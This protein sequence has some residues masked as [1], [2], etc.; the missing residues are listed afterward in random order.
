[1]TNPVKGAPPRLIYCKPWQGGWSDGVKF[2]DNVIINLSE[3]TRY[4]EGHSTNN[5]YSHNLF[6]GVHPSTEPQDPMKLLVSPLLVK[7]DGA[8]YGLASAIAAYSPKAG[9]PEVGAG[10]ALRRE[11]EKN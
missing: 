11:A 8:K 5:Q 4:T 1:M 3:H 2:H 9:A 7:A 6:F 10:A